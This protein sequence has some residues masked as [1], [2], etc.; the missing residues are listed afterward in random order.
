MSYYYGAA[1]AAGKAQGEEEPG[2]T[3]GARPAFVLAG[4]A[5]ENTTV[6]A[7]HQ[8]TYPATVNSGE[9][10]VVVA[11]ARGAGASNI[12]LA[13]HADAVSAGW[14]HV[15]GSPLSTADTFEK[16]LVA[17]RTGLAGSEDGSAMEGGIVGTAAVETETH[18]HAVIFTVS[19][20]D[21]FHATPIEDPDSTEETGT[22]V[23]GPTVTPEDTNRLAVS[24]I[25]FSDDGMGAD[26]F[27]GASATW[28]EHIDISTALQTD[29]TIQV[30]TAPADGEVSGGSDTVNIDTIRLRFSFAIAPADVE[31]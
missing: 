28:T 24:I 29:S 3:P 5:Y 14:T 16:L 22:T 7:T 1:S 2:M 26:A 18:I 11:W 10:A 23:A 13:L 20:A 19:A 27:A 15:T 12:S 25:G 6:A 30:Q 21:G 31:A 17:Y 8:P 4:T 9:M